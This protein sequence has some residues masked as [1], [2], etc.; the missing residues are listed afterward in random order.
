MKL[1]QQSYSFILNELIKSFTLMVNFLQK[2]P[3]LFQLRYCDR[4]LNE[5]EH[6]NN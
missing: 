3:N 6:S 1:K 2:F 5:S 4:F